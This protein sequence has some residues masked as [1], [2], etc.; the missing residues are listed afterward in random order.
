MAPPYAPTR[1]RST[2][3][4]AT[5]AAL[6]VLAT[7]LAPAAIA[8]P[9]ATPQAST[10]M[11]PQPS[12]NSSADVVETTAAA[13]GDETAS[14]TLN[15]DDAV[16]FAAS[17]T[18]ENPDIEYRIHTAD[19]WQEWQPVDP[20]VDGADHAHDHA[21][22]GDAS[23]SGEPSTE[24]ERVSDALIVADADRLEARAANEAYAGALDITAYTSQVTQTDRNVTAPIASTYSSGNESVLDRVIPRS[25]WGAANALCSL[26]T[27]PKKKGVLIHHTAGSNDYSRD[28]VP[29]ILRGIQQFHMSK[30]PTWCDIGYHM[31]VDKWGNIYEGRAGGLNLAVVGTHAAGWNGDMF[32]VSV[33]GDYTYA[34]PSSGVIKSLQEVVG[35]QAKYWGYDPRARATMIAGGG[36]KYAAGQSVTLNRVSGHRDVGWTSCPGAN[37]YA[38][39]DTIRSGAVQYMARE[40][41]KVGPF[42]D[43]GGTA[44]A[45]HILWL[46]QE[47]VTSG[48]TDGT[49]R[50][51][52]YVSRLE[53]ATFLYR[54]HGPTGYSGPKVDP[55]TDI[56]K[57]HSYAEEIG[58]AKLKEITSGYTDGRFGP[59][60]TITRGQMASFLYSYTQ[61]VCRINRGYTPPNT[62]RFEDMNVGGAFYEAVSWAAARGITSGYSDGTFRPSKPT[63][64]GEMAAFLKNLDDFVGNR[65]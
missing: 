41:V 60:D 40:H 36:G 33:M 19:G 7:M 2:H 49:F 56:P 3:V 13:D 45:Q 55:Y 17:W 59:Q 12:A 52:R 63:T 29:G 32:G 20:E 23:T 42:L 8:Q 27:T 22:G 61:N 57:T 44:F 4:L 35:W 15:P 43:V 65:C 54:Y 21:D 62:S 34:T 51:T 50:P 5:T 39:M 16:V 58:W 53:M 46:W 14:L 64:R 48:Y 24:D 47:G 10:P 25:S 31:L 9:A 28:Q 37:L 26:G 38:M 18:G 6:A 1:R 11:A 30:D